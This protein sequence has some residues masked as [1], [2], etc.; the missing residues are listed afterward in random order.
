MVRLLVLITQKL[1]N[2]TQSASR[3]EIRSKRMAIAAILPFAMFLERD[4]Q[5]EMF[6]AVLCTLRTPG[7]RNMWHRIEPYIGTQLEK[8]NLPSLD[9]FIALASYKITYSIKSGRLSVARWAAAVLA[10]PYTEEVG[11]SVV[12]ATLLIARYDILRPQIPADIWTLLRNQPSL[13]PV[14]PGRT[15]GTTGDV[16]RHIRGLGDL[17]ILKSYLLLVWSE[18][19]PLRLSGANEM[20]VSIW[21]DFD[22]IGMWAHREDLVKRLDHVLG[23]LDRGPKWLRTYNRVFD[24]WKFRVSKE[25]YGELRDVLLEVDR[26][27][28]VVLTREPPELTVSNNVLIITDDCV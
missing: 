19:D 2:M 12:D 7:L 25:Q 18:W 16:V 6:D 28:M 22:G 9:K 5:P 24:E 11:Q 4:G 27:T 8:S 20:E 21:E 3:A 13:P 17:E 1:K 23:R 14:C 15:F 26:E 10:V